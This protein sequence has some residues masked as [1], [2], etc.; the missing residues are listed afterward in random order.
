MF[1]LYVKNAKANFQEEYR[2]LPSLEIHNVI[3]YVMPSLKL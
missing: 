2:A 3:I 1:A